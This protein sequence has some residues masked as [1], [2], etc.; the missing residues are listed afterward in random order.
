MKTLTQESS[1]CRYQN[2]KTRIYFGT[3]LLVLILFIGFMQ[4]QVNAVVIGG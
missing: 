3:F 2:F 1:S 4:K